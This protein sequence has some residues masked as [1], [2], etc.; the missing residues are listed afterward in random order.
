M[1][2]LNTKTRRLEEFAD[3]TPL[4]A[5][6]S[7]RWG[8]DEAASHGFTY[9]WI[10]TC[11]IDKTS[12]A[13]LSEAID[14]MYRWYQ[15]ATVC[16]AYLADV[17]CN[18]YDLQSGTDPHDWFGRGWMRQELI[19][20][21]LVVFFNKSWGKVGTKSTLCSLVSEITGIPDDILTGERNVEDASVAQRMSWAAWRRTTRAEDRAYCLMGIFG[22]NMPMLY[23]EGGTNAFMRLQE[24]ILKFSNDHSIFAWST[25]GGSSMEN[26]RDLLA[27]SPAYFRNSGWVVE[28]SEIGVTVDFSSG[29]ITVDKRGIHLELTLRSGKLASH[30][31]QTVAESLIGLGF[32]LNVSNSTE[33]TPLNMALQNGQGFTS[34]AE[35]QLTT[36]NNFNLEV[37]ADPY[38]CLV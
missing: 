25:G 14:S 4:Y 12:S 24:E 21:S 5:I 16:Y 26:Y 38:G 31:D 27:P 6:L 22:V 20:P 3:D 30:G 35:R 2:L 34:A 11:C 7:H 9:V 13:E 36:A 15:E 17:E 8:D 32:G 18:G 37:L 29:T 1:R 10:D 33:G 28:P 23:G 19:A